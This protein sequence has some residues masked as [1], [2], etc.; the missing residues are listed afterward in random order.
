MHRPLANRQ[1]TIVGYGDQI[2]DG[3][4]IFL[5]SWNEGEVLGG[6][7][8][9]ELPRGQVRVT[10]HYG[11]FFIRS[12]GDDECMVPN[13]V[14]DVGAWCIHNRLSCAGEGNIQL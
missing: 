2:E 3:C 5:K 7:T 13:Y 12:L 14:V 8:C 6:H 4:G 1:T 9:P 11:V 10:M